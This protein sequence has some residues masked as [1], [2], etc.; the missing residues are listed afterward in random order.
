MKKK[1]LYTDVP[2]PYNENTARGLRRI[3]MI[4]VTL[5]IMSGCLMLINL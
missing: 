5:L 4:L 1:I 2:N 3:A